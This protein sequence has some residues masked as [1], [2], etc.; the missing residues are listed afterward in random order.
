MIVAIVGS[1]E[2]SVLS[3]LQKLRPESVTSLFPIA[4]VSLPEGEEAA[5]TFSIEKLG[6]PSTFVETFP[7]EDSL[8]LLRPF[9]KHLSHLEGHL[10]EEG[11]LDTRLSRASA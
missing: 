11:L 10:L 7:V 3:I 6:H 8:N 4:K 2:D 5:I 9:A 1:S